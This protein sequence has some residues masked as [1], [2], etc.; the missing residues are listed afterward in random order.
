MFVGIDIGKQSL[1]A[2]VDGDDLL[3]RGTASQTYQP[4]FP[5]PG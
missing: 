1:K 3:P 2:V 5:K 4:D